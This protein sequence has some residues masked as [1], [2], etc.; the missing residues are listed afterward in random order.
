MTRIR[1][2]CAH[3]GSEDITYDALV[4][5]DVDLQDWTFSTLLDAGACENCGA[6]LW[7]KD[8][9]DEEIVEDQAKGDQP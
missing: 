8:I 2:V 9:R 3:C 6:E 4:C 1:K 7:E 5:W